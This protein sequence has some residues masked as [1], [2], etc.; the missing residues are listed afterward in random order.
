MHLHSTSN[1]L[2]CQQVDIKILIHL[3]N[4]ISILNI[5]KS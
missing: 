1:Y 3:V 2:V 5:P 4:F